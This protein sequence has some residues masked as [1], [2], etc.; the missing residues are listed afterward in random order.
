MRIARLPFGPV[1][2][3]IHGVAVVDPYRWLEDRGLPETDDWIREQQRYCGKYFAEITALDQLR[4][5]VREYLDVEV[6]DQLARTKDRYFYRRR[7]RRQEQAA[8]YMLDMKTGEERLLVDPSQHRPFVSF[9]IHRIATDGSLLAYEVKHGG[10][11]RKCIS[12]L[13]V[14]SGIVLP[15]GLEVGCARGFAFTQT[16][17]GFY[18]CHETGEGDSGEHIIYLHRFGHTGRDQAVFTVPQTP[19]SRLLLTANRTHLGAVWLHQADLGIVADFAI[20]PIAENLAWKTVFRNKKLPYNPFLCHDMIFAAVQNDSGNSRIIELSEDGRELRT[21]V[22]ERETRVR[23]LVIT[24]SKLYASYLEDGVPS[25]HAWDLEGK[26][27]G[28]IA[29][30]YDG[31]IR[32]IGNLDQ[33]EDHFFYTYESF[34][35]PPI[36]FEYACGTGA[37]T[38]WHRQQSFVGK[39]H[40]QVREVSYP[41]KDGT[42]IPLTMVALEDTNL[43]GPVPIVMTSYG[44][45]GAPVTPQFSVLATIMMERGVVFALPHIRG[46]GEFGKRWHDA[47][48][49]R[50]RQNA[51]DD[52][53]GA[54]EWLCSKGI[55]TAKQLAIFGGSNAGLLVG[56]VLTQRPDLFRAV[57]CIAP[58]LD[59]VRYE[60]FGQAHKWCGEYGTVTDPEDFLALHAYSPYH[61][62][63]QGLNYPPTLFVTGDK[64]DRCD[65]AHVRKMVARLQDGSRQTSPIIVDYISQRGH[66]PVLPLSTR[67]DALT[68]KIAFLCTELGIPVLLGENP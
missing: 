4:E 11:D 51:F 20:A 42:E 58:L 26:S 40:F 53:L 45:F 64:D 28:P 31:S 30:P 13:H 9:H 55:T 29:L 19:E 63:Q 66:S 46:G 23:Q 59:M 61:R 38:V 22:P 43:D 60:Q 16:N 3:V 34:S 47:G 54:A 2:E 32:L 25:V 18:Y 14:Q 56:A 7:A 5:R 57:L 27:L 35:Q 48:R 41:S 17:N 49:S 62:V 67:V 52:F 1:T 65:P 37:S 24:R 6:V 10:E 36:V 68:R 21:V 8:I 33:D 50:N 39:G 44:G 15:D 12:V